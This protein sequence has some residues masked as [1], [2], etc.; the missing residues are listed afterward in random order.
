M[1]FMTHRRVVV[2]YWYTNE[3][4]PVSLSTSCRYYSTSHSQ[5]L[6]LHNTIQYN[7]TSKR[8]AC[9]HIVGFNFHLHEHYDFYY[10]TR[11]LITARECIA[12]LPLPPPQS[13]FPTFAGD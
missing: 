9:C 7:T 4:T 12:S 5:L 13:P 10:C 8:L 1:H 3:L 11:L 6:L 2:H